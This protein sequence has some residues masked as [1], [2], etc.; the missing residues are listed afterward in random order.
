VAAHAWALTGAR[1]RMVE[2]QAWALRLR[3][4]RKLR[5]AR[6][7]WQS[8]AAGHALTDQIRAP[9]QRVPASSAAGRALALALALVS[10][11]WSLPLWPR[12]ATGLKQARELV[13]KPASSAAGRAL[14]LALALALVSP[15]WSWPLWPRLATGL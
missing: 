10:P 6:L 4:V 5:L 15:A 3:F 12:L 1:L 7:V 2:G 14:A 9:K 8:S 11:A 13:P